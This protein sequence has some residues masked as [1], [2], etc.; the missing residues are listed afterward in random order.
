MA[1]R[2][3]Q[4]WL[5]VKVKVPSKLEGAVSTVLSGLIPSLKWKDQR[6]KDGTSLLTTAVL[7]NARVDQIISEIEEALQRFE[8]KHYLS[9]PLSV[10]LQVFKTDESD[11]S[12]HNHIQPL[13]V[14]PR[15]AVGSPCQPGYTGQ[16]RKVLLID[17]QEAFGDG[18]HPS[19]RIALRLLDEFLNGQHGPPPVVDEWVLDAGC[20]SGVLALAA[21]A[22]GGFKVLAVDLDPQAI[23]ATRNNL[24]LNSGPGSKVFLAMG[25]LSCA[26]GPFCIVLANLVPTLQTRAYKTLWRAVAPGGW[27]ILSGFCQAQKEWI[28]RPYIQNGATE[29]ACYLE[30]AWAGVLLYKPK[31]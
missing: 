20:G 6:K 29:K 26:Q 27:L 21:A 3:V 12:R 22:L 2:K 23:N 14:S 9:E 15:L 17:A 16:D 10:D 31:A 13:K 7:M 30:Q 19:T 1:A 24:M 25:E 5:E 28:L 4:S 18:K 8:T 11:S